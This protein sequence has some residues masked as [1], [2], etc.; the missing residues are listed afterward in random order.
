MQS[1]KVINIIITLEFKFTSLTQGI[2]IIM[3]VPK[4]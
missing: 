1:I 2:D 3:D 4:Q